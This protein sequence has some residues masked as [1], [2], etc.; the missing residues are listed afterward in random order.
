MLG[1]YPRG[2]VATARIATYLFNYVFTICLLK[3]HV[4][5]L[6]NMF[7]VDITLEPAF[8]NPQ[9]K[10]IMFPVLWYLGMP[11]LQSSEN[12]FIMLSKK[13]LFT[14]KPEASILM[15]WITQKSVQSS[16]PFVYSAYS[17][18]S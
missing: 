9:L 4:P 15:R 16:E 6:T 18:N 13:R 12:L 8:W 14:K 10:P 2:D 17:V 11:L 1:K 7:L 3:F 5:G